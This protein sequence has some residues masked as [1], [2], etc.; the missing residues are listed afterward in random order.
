MIQ[1][2]ECL[3]GKFARMGNVIPNLFHGPKVPSREVKTNYGNV[4]GIR[5]IDKGERQVDAFLGIPFAK[6]PLGELRFRVCF[7][8]GGGR[9]TVTVTVSIPILKSLSLETPTS[10]TLGRHSRSHQVRSAFN[11][12]RRV[13]FHKIQTWFHFRRLPIPKCIHARMATTAWR[14]CCYGE[15]IKVLKI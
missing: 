9:A 12:K 5:M 11:S 4:V 2:W 14:F 1:H 15:P 10:R 3:F 6:P 13:L 7:W 8:W